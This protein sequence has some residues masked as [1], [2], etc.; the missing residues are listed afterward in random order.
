MPETSD[1]TCCECSEPSDAYA[2]F[3][4]GSGWLCRE[5]VSADALTNSMN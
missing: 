1:L 2:S 5:C 4:D 3:D